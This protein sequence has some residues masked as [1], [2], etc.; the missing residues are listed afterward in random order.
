ML[1]ELEEL[2][3]D[4]QEKLENV[5]YENGV[6]NLDKKS[7]IITMILVLSLFIISSCARNNVKKVVGSEKTYDDLE[8]SFSY[9]HNEVDYLKYS[10]VAIDRGFI[11]KQY[12]V[13]S[14]EY[15][16]DDT[17]SVL[18]FSN[19]NSDNRF[20]LLQ[21]ADN[22]LVEIWI[23]KSGLSNNVI[24]TLDNSNYYEDVLEI[25]YY[26]ELRIN[27]DEAQSYHITESGDFYQILYV[28]EN[29]RWKIEKVLEMPNDSKLLPNI[30]G[31][32]YKN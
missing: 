29:K 25:D 1:Y 9:D 26:C 27:E 31:D 5:M 15:V 17:Y 21:N 11:I 24:S 12:G 30:I 7:I 22:V 19:E 8:V 28:F 14:N 32:Y 20:V 3:F 18:I 16:L 2:N 23:M 13:P 10:S 6:I 4:A